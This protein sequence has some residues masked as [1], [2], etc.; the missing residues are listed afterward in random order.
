M[1]KYNLVYPDHYNYSEI[2]IK[3]IKEIAKAKK[4]KILTTEKDFY[5]IPIKLRKNI[6]FIKINLKVKK[7]KK[8]KQ[9]VSKYL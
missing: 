7:L 6:N 8:F 3:K 5:R 1:N 9:F 4:L 2:D